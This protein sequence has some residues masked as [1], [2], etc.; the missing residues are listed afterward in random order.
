MRFGQVVVD[1][2]LAISGHGTTE[3][4]TSARR[5]PPPP[6]KKAKDAEVLFAK[7]R[8]L[9]TALEAKPSRREDYFGDRPNIKALREDIA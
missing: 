8:T 2:T 1:R 6:K 9:E 4:P 5:N 3:R 7:L